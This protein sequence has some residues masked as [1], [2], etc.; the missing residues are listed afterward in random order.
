MIK[1]RTEHPLQRGVNLR[2]QAAYPVRDLCDLRGEIVKMV[3]PEDR[4]LAIEPGQPVE[5]VLP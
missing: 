4:A 2:K 3:L 5:V 1:P